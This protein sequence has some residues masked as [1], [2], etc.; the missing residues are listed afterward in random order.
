MVNFL[1]TLLVIV[2][3]NWGEFLKHTL[4]NCDGEFLK[5]QLLV[6]VTVNCSE[7]LQHTLSNLMLVCGEFN[8]GLRS[9]WLIAADFIKSLGPDKLK[10]LKTVDCDRFHQSFIQA[11]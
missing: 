8:Q 7:F 2:T 4:S 6:V 11:T 5:K 10:S 3:L 9:D 1:N